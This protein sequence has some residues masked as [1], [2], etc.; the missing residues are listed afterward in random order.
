M[1][2]YKDCDI[3]GVYPSELTENEAYKIGR[4]LATLHPGEWLVGGDVR[5]S[6]PALKSALMNG[7]RASGANVT[8]L[9][10]IPTPALYFALKH[11]SAQSGA[12]VTASHNPPDHNGVKFM[13]GDL[14][15]TR[16]EIDRVRACVQS[17]E[18][19]EGAGSIRTRDVLTEYVDFMSARFPAKR[20]LKVL[21]D[22]GNGA[23]SLAAPEV[24][25]RAGYEVTELDCVP[26]GRFPSRSPNPS[27]FANLRGT[28]RAVR[29]ADVDFGV[30]FDGD[31]DRAVFL[32]AQG[33]P[34]QIEKILVL[35]IREALKN[36]PSSVVF[37]QKSSSV[38]RKAILEMGGTPLPERSGHA[39]IK[40]RF[41]ENNSALAGEVSG[42]YF[43][44]EPGYDDG[45]F[46]ALFLAD[47][48]ARSGKTLAELADEIVC[49]PVT[50][51]L[52]IPC[53]YAEQDACLART[54]AAAIERGAVIS[55]LDGVRADFP[56]G[57]FLLRKS[58]TSEQLTLR[59]E[60]ENEA[61]LRELVAF[62]RDLLPEKSREFL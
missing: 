8:D 41:L 1:S 43:F 35:F 27:D 53:P 61:R 5:L 49:P 21:I 48:L 12:T 24:F 20:P 51:D 56:D 37:D 34:V 4:A 30:A 14:P 32:D 46:A 18:F 25:R 28:A 50:P 16:A 42:H 22:A 31:G 55:R 44:R 40:R 26:D 57:W 47:I 2:I 59:V 54:E 17:G 11:S 58:V 19:A 23:M 62:A 6:T 36:A 3:R 7:L 52:R 10:R 13:C 39:F 60:A 15:V 29:A 9:G 38:V 33:T 45:L